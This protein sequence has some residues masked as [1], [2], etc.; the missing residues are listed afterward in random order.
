MAST[1][2]RETP[3]SSRS[4]NV[5]TAT[6]LSPCS[7]ATSTRAV[8]SGAATAKTPSAS[9]C[10]RIAASS[11]ASR[12][13][14]CCHILS[15]IRV[16]SSES[17]TRVSAS[18]RSE[19]CIFH[20]AMPPKKPSSLATAS[21]DGSSINGVTDASAASTMRVTTASSSAVLESK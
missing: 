19:R 8:S 11:G 6:S 9:P 3:L 14:R 21:S 5:R 18:M 4:T 12:A 16:F 17:Q 20:C 15:R 10:L 13:I 2:A 1:S 7:R